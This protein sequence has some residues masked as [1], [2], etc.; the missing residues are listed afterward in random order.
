MKVSH[1]D[2]T[3]LPKI[4]IVTPSY[5]QAEFLED[6]IKSVLNQDYP[7][8]EY[9]IVDGGSTDGSV[10]II[11]KY[12]EQLAYWESESDK[13]QYDALNKGL[14]R[15]T[16][17]IMAYINSDDKYTP[18][19]FQVIADIFSSLPE[20]E[21]VTS[22]YPLQWDEAGRAT[23]CFHLQGF[24][25]QAFYR[26]VN[27]PGM[28]WYAHGF[29]QQES[30]FWRRSLWERAG[31]YINHTLG[32][33]GDFELWAR[34]WLHGELYGV[35]TPLGGFRIH[36][37]QKTACHMNDYRREAN[38]ILREYGGHPYGK[39]ESVLRRRVW[40]FLPAFVR[41]FYASFRL[42]YPTKELV[43]ECRKG[44]WKTTTTYIV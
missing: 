28:G 27:L 4:S 36:K 5:N 19:T 3:V 10:D 38:A 11:R 17:E 2:N 16:G 32:Y 37:N 1:C 39:L 42:T 44:Y 26:G 6:A 40:S 12:T 18:W 14:A 21:W 9:I 31:G 30:T 20:V 15:T 7:N 25:R 33:A 23:N 24:N 43:Y 8:T 22:A 35:C 29:I 41:P 34:F 13:G